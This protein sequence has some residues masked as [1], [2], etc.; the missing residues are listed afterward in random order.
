[1][2]DFG[3]KLR[4]L[5]VDKGI[6]Q[7]DLARKMNLTQGSISQFEKGLRLPTPLNIEK[8]C[9]ILGVSRESLVGKEEQKSVDVERVRLMRNIQSL[10]AENLKTLNEV[11][12]AMRG[13]PEKNRKG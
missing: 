9:G 13:K 7:D 3:Q 4:E 2:N 5:R 12:E 8:L 6:S 10:P 11:A 1:M